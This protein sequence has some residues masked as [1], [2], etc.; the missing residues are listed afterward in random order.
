MNFAP[1]ILFGSI[2]LRCGVRC[3]LICSWI[4]LHARDGDQQRIKRFFK[5]IF[6]FL[7]L[8]ILNTER[9]AYISFSFF[10][11]VDDTHC[12]NWLLNFEA[13]L[14]LFQNSFLLLLL[15]ISIGLIRRLFSVYCEFFYF[16]LPVLHTE[17]FFMW[18]MVFIGSFKDFSSFHEF[19]SVL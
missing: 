17:S 15:L 11:L 7:C 13:L 8:S 16:C 14:V 3:I 10:F 2:K 9:D 18:L 12:L 19:F 4:S 5:N 6:R 1:K